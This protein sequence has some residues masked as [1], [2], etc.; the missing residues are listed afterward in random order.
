[1][2]NLYTLS[3]QV[4][5]NLA[6]FMQFLPVPQDMA[7][8]TP[9]TTIYRN[10]ISLLELKVLRKRNDRLMREKKMT[11]RTLYELKFDRK[12]STLS[13][14]KRYPHYISKISNLALLDL[15]EETLRRVIREKRKLYYLQRL[16]RRLL[17]SRN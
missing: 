16:R 2:F 4:K 6:F 13:L 7:V 3:N 5:P 11:Y 14:G 9:E 17:K 1:M 10:E 12:M 15:T 8:H